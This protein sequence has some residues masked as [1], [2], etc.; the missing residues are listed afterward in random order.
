[1]DDPQKSSVDDPQ[2]STIEDPQPPTTSDPKAALAARMARFQALQTA[3]ETGKKATE[4][5]ARNEV[6]HEK[7]NR[8][9]AEA[10]RKS[11]IYNYKLLR[12]E[13]PAAFERKR[14]WD[15]TI[16]ESEQWDKRVKKKSR[17]RDAVAFSDWR[18]EAGKNYKRQV[19]Q[20]TS[21]DLAAYAQKKGEILQRQVTSGLLTLVET[22]SGDVFTVDASGRVNT[23]VDESYGCDHVPSK[24][25]V[26]RLVGDLEKAERARMEARRKRGIEGG[27]EK[28]DVTYINL[29][30]KQFNEKLARFYNRYTEEIRGNF[31]RGTAV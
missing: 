20:M 21:V 22:A 27:E 14:A 23:P 17:N 31:E 15:Y 6:D 1:M 12:D 24:E 28:A 11:D 16:D 29:K 5:A 13:D 4:K 25:A 26:D 19:S 10:Q 18:A 9:L 3:R 7:R 8:E 2:K 30:N